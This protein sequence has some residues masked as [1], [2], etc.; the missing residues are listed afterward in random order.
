MP[1]WLMQCLLLVAALA[2]C[3]G[4]GRTSET[5]QAASR[6]E[7]QVLHSPDRNL[8]VRF[9]L[10]GGTPRF[11]VWFGGEPLLT[12]SPLGFHFKNA[13]PLL[14][15][16]RIADIRRDSFDETWEPVWGTV[17][18]IR[19]HYHELSVTL[20]EEAAPNRRVKIVFRAFDD[21][22]AFRYT[23]PEQE[24]MREFQILSEET[25]FC[26]AGNFSAWW[27]PADYDSYERLYRNSPLSGLVAANTP[28]TLETDQ[29]VA[30][31]I[32]E[33]DLTDYAGMTLIN[34]AS[35]RKGAAARADSPAGQTL[36][37][38]LVPWPDGVKV[39]GSVPFRTP[40]RTIQIASSSARL[41]ESNLLLNLN[42]PCRIADTSWIQPMK[43]VGIWWGMHIGKWTW[44]AGPK[45]GATTEHAKQY[46]DFAAAHGFPGVLIEG[47][48]QGWESW[49]GG[50][51]EQ[52]YTKPYPDFDL[53][54]VVSYGRERGVEIIGHH[55]SGGNVPHYEKQIE[56][57]FAYYRQLGIRAI[58]TGYAGKMHP[59]GQHH[60]GQW[61]V[62]HY[63]MVV[64]KA[65]DYG[66]MI[67]AHEP[68]KDTGIR[69]TWPNMMTREGSRGMEYNA[70]SEGNP[71][72]HTTVLPFTRLL[73][74]P[75]DYTPGI[76]DLTFDDF[77]PG[78][79]VHTTLAR[80][81]AY[82]VVLYSPLQMA[83]DLVE[84]YENQPAFRFIEDVPA[85]WDDT[86]V[87]AA[88]IGDYVAI[89]RRR[90]DEWFVGAITDEVTRRLDL[91]FD[92][93]DPSSE[94]VVQIYADAL[95]TNWEHSPAAIEIGTY[96]MQGSDP[97]QAVLSPAGG[98]AMR[99]LPA[100]R[101]TGV[102]GAPAAEF[103]PLTDF[104]ATADARV[105]AY[106]KIRPFGTPTRIHHAGVGCGIEVTHPCSPKYPAG[107]PA[108]LIDGSRGAANHD[109][110][111]QG[112]E[113]RDLEAVI[114]L[115]SERSI[116]MIGA[117][118]LQ[119]PAYW[120]FFPTQITF[121]I[122]ADGANF[123]TVAW[124]RPPPA[125]TDDDFAIETFTRDVS[126][127]KARYVRV[128]AKTIGHCPPWHS[129]AGG[130]AWIFADEI[131]VK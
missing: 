93:L 124:F 49:L 87:L 15:G 39:K 55:E 48:N 23:F 33:A 114:D 26:L 44:H 77:K 59:A 10:T 54:A 111:W 88:A 110:N 71:P 32:H 92:F 125:T 96:R 69:R 51:N 105:E 43:Y 99:V 34:A 8:E 1:H 117:G 108:A 7:P 74:G 80:Q 81:L 65:A 66:M 63:R 13:P 90:N 14:D 98:L 6:E 50:K 5:E 116:S 103:P 94:Y 127:K 101:S 89:G 128:R 52:D 113:A 106:A 58:K 11:A 68:I 18:S 70:W 28:V 24:A 118:F 79:R 35:S 46:I 82:Y 83:A 122:S 62:R 91:A 112:F 2:L 64:E 97:L 53:E 41:A 100:D 25:G 107:G 29:G 130:D 3:V 19:N 78:N 85:D 9:T 22:L 40:W 121:A 73:T 20:D 131:I 17:K 129:G 38:E 4:T 42:E 61:M 95:E 76:F 12:P 119:K 104:N 57:A 30:L 60:H 27:S 45:H 56:A 36:L 72:E 47:W 86:R 84:N 120:I 31:C 67:D 109:V 126:G 16:L 37:C 102:V 115:G 123:E 75:M 21:G